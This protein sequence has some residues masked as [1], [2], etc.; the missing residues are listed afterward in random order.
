MLQLI[1]NVPLKYK[2][3][4]LNFVVLAVLL[5]LVLYGMQQIATH[6]NHPFKDVLLVS[7]PGFAGVV[8]VLMILEMACSQI[9]ISFIERHVHQLK[10]TMVAVQSTGNLSQRAK[11]DSTDEIGEM[12]TAFNA[13]QQRT[14]EVVQSIQFAVQRLETE[15]AELSSATEHSRDKLQRQQTETERSAATIEAMLA[16]FGGIASQ[17]D[18]ARRLS[19]LARQTAQEGANR[20][21]QSSRSIQQLAQTIE[22]SAASVQALASNSREIGGAVSEI[23]G[24]AEQTNLLALNAAIEAARAG[25]QGRGFAVVADEVRNLAQRV[26]DSTEQIQH[27]IDRLLETTSGAV[28]QMTA[29]SEKATHCVDEAN[30][31]KNALDDINSAIH[32]IND[33]NREIAEV[34]AEHTASTDMI[35]DSMQS[36]RDTTQSMV[37][38]LASHAEMGQRLRALIRELEN[39]SAQ[40]FVEAHKD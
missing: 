3:W 21:E 19:G 13:M 36:V 9:L 29:S 17:A 6:S 5:L 12:A 30:A 25:E 24:I 22:H 28:E 10:D 14:G 4:L 2:F 27:T 31:G 23:R 8:L 15:I 34:S 33:T 16:G 37:Q 7:A 38:Q 35:Q 18:A 32:S 40:V 26:Q 39:A 20:V 11:V 1:K